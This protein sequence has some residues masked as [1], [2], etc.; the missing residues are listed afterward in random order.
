M[1]SDRFIFYFCVSLHTDIHIY[2]IY[3][4]TN[5]VYALF[6]V[7]NNESKHLLTSR[8]N[9]G[10]FIIIFISCGTMIQ[11][12]GLILYQIVSNLDNIEI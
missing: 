1:F 3:V 9:L 8:E 5:I 4:A 6:T 7:Y 2:Y 11:G 10:Y 12:L